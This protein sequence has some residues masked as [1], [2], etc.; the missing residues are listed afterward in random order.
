MGLN[1]CLVS[2]HFS[3]KDCSVL[4]VGQV[5]YNRLSVFVFFFSVNF[6]IFPSFLKDRF[7]AYRIP[8]LDM[9]LFFK[10]LEYVISLL[11]GLCSALHA[12]RCNHS[13]PRPCSNHYAI[14][15]NNGQCSRYLASSNTSFLKC[16]INNFISYDA[17]SCHGFLEFCFCQKN[18][19]AHSS[20]NQIPNTL[21]HSLFSWPLLVPILFSQETSFNRDLI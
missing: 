3:L 20:T 8:W 18:S 11:S 7:V 6:S 16:F 12:F 15:A 4:L 13:K 10:H 14:M 19:I 5:F 1:Y 9:L 2:F 21:F 17:I